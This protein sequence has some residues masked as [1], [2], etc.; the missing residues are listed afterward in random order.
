MSKENE[1]QRAQRMFALAEAAADNYGSWD[2]VPA[3]LKQRV[4]ES[5]QALK[6]LQA[7]SEVT[8]TEHAEIESL[9]RRIE[10]RQAN[11][12]RQ[13]VVPGCEPLVFHQ[14]SVRC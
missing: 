5:E 12:P 14:R 2:D 1:L 9:I 3:P 11:E 7:L 13:L 4:A 8:E 10:H 6:R